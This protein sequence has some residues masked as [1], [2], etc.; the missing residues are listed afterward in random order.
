MT[1]RQ[2]EPVGNKVRAPL[3]G[4]FLGTHG[5]SV[6]SIITVPVLVY[7]MLVPSYTDPTVRIDRFKTLHLA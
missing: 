4:V 6:N 7:S 3:E 2:L 5:G 1:A